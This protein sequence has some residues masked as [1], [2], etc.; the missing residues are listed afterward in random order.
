MTSRIEPRSELAE[1]LPF[2]DPVSLVP[3]VSPLKVPHVRSRE[4]DLEAALAAQEVA[5]RELEVSRKVLCSFQENS[6]Q[7]A[8][9][10]DA[11]GAYLSYN[12]TFAKFY[13]IDKELWIGKTTQDV[14]PQ[15]VDHAFRAQESAVIDSR[16]T[17]EMLLR[18]TIPDRGEY[19]FRS[20]KFPVEGKSSE[21]L[22]G[23]IDIDVTEDVRRQEHL[24]AA[25]R[26]LEM[27]ARTDSLTGLYSRGT[28]D[29]RLEREYALS[30]RKNR[31][32]ALLVLDIDNFKSRND[33]YGHAAGDDAL[34]IVGRVLRN[35]VRPGE[36]AARLGGEEFAIML[37]ETSLLEACTL[38]QR[39]QA[40]LADYECASGPIHVSIGVAETDAQ[41]ASWHELLAKADTAMYQAKRGGKNSVVRSAQ[42]VF[43]RLPSF[44]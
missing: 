42:G 25:Y 10:K 18:F 5:I 29:D 1:R 13:G 4:A 2:G 30:E 34:R 43:T 3:R 6:P 31:S 27:L 12:C 37:P 24:E 8:Y 40:A 38:A 16:Q 22:V 9:I 14:L 17:A 41:I 11:N 15:M 23:G 39:V 26:R 20:I 32:I 36:V 28:F 7:H 35:L 33:T 21:P 44:T 19:V